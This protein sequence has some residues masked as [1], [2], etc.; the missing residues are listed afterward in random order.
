MKSIHEKILSEMIQILKIVENV[1]SI[2]TSNTI[3]SFILSD[4]SLQWNFNINEVLELQLNLC[5][6]WSL[7]QLN[8]NILLPGKT[9]ID[10]IQSSKPNL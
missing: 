3:F 4:Y 2:L 6:L 8:S 5:D 10:K 9:I 7:V 1:F